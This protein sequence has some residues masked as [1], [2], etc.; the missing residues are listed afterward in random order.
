[1]G[2]TYS[3]RISEGTKMKLFGV[4]FAV[5]L[6]ACS[7]DR[8]L[9]STKE[10]T[11]SLDGKVLL[12]DTDAFYDIAE[13]AVDGRPF[14]DIHGVK[15]SAHLRMFQKDA[16]AVVTYY[17]CVVSP[18]EGTNWITQT[19]H[20]LLSKNEQ[21]FV[22]LFNDNVEVKALSSS[23]VDG[24]FYK[25]ESFAFSDFEEKVKFEAVLAPFE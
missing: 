17:Y 4:V 10:G 9:D 16:T 8:D 21:K 5:L 7:S 14:V 11:D 24:L 18:C 25:P 1:M 23:V 6:V 12:G 13:G 19:T 22:T 20:K 2:Y 3:V 15:G